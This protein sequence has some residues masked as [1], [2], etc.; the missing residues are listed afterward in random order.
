[1]IGNMLKG[2]IGSRRFAVVIAWILTVVCRDKLGIPLSPEMIEQL[3]LLLAALVL[4][5][6]YQSANQAPKAPPATP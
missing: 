2:L 3:S 4:G 5:E 6:S 1:M